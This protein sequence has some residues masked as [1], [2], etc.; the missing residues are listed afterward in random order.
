MDNS[1]RGQTRR[2]EREQKSEP[3]HFAF[4]C[5]YLLGD[6]RGIW[7]ARKDIGLADTATRRRMIAKDR[8]PDMT[9]DPIRYS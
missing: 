1:G 9:V 8:D 6:E 4:G 5:A 7:A 2:T 3:Y